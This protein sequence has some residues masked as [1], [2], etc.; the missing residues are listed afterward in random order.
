[1]Y[2]ICQA[3]YPH[4]SWGTGHTTKDGCPPQ[5]SIPGHDSGVLSLY[6]Q[7]KDRNL[8]NNNDYQNIGVNGARVTSSMNLVNA[9]AR[10]PANDQPL[11]LWM[12]LIGNDV[13]K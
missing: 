8:C 7:M 6:S 13:C 2:G 12:P 4:C 10:D 5:H 11:L 1:M 9:L 3:D